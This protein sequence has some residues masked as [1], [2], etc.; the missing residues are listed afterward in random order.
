MKMDI[1]R[2]IST[3]KRLVIN[4]ERPLRFD[5]AVLDLAVDKDLLR[6]I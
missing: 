4:T 5:Y 2:Y 3:L 6:V 1:A